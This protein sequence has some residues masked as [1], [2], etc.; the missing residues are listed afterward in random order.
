MP[1]HPIFQT[2]QDANREQYV[3]LRAAKLL[4]ANLRPVKAHGPIDGIFV[5]DGKDVAVEIKSRHPKYRKRIEEDGVMLSLHR[6]NRLARMKPALFI[7]SFGYGDIFVHDV[8]DSEDYEA[9]TMRTVQPRSPDKV[10][11]VDKVVFIPLD[12]FRK[13][14]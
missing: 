8:T 3:L 7:V 12:K 4:G 14:V 9:K 13:L 6:Y 10:V 5:I 1:R 11:D 2:K